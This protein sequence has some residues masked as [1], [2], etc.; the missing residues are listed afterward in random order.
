MVAAAFI[1]GAGA[2]AAEPV[3]VVEKCASAGVLVEV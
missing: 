1:A 3:A 2:L